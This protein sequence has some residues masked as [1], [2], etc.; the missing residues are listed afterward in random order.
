MTR[1][2]RIVSHFILLLGMFFYLIPSLSLAFELGETKGEIVFSSNRSGPWRI[3][4]VRA[5]G[6]EMRQL[7]TASDDENDVDP[8]FSP[9]GSKIL[10]TSTRGGTVGIWKMSLN[11]EEPERLCDGDQAEWSPDGK[12]IVFRRN[13]KLFIR[14]LAQQNEKQIT[15]DEWPHCSGPSWSPDNN[16]I[17]FASRWDAGNGIFVVPADGGLPTKVYDKKGACEPH[18]SPDG[19]LLVYETETHL[20]TIQLDGNKNRPITYYGGVQRYAQWSPD[21]QY[22]V[23]CQGVSETGPWELY[24]T[25]SSGGAPVRLT[26][27]GSDMNPDWK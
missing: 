20:C 14:D 27:G 24:I 3:W 15:P 6:S 1:K 21:G 22:L 9:D 17:A 10:F 23:Y 2:Y 7:T 11:H 26:E 5:D 18:W 13:E 16:T 12:K 8:A 19:S 4:M 25:P